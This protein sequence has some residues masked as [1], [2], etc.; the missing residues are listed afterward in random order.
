[1]IRRLSAWSPISCAATLRISAAKTSEAQKILVASGAQQYTEGSGGCGGGSGGTREIFDRRNGIRC[2]PAPRC[3]QPISA[4]RS[5]RKHRW[6][7]T[8]TKRTGSRFKVVAVRGR[9][10]RWHVWSMRMRAMVNFYATSNCPTI[11][12]EAHKTALKGAPTA[13]VDEA[14][15]RA[16]E[17]KASCAKRGKED[18]RVFRC[19]AQLSHGRAVSRTRVDVFSKANVHRVALPP[20]TQVLRQALLKKPKS[21]EAAAQARRS[22]FASRR[23]WRSGAPARAQR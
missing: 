20:R 14:L 4:D 18:D 5:A 12:P 7:R 9:L 13:K 21:G 16:T 2:A 23:R 22:V 17:L 19:G 1:M 8:P 3:K 6:S 15:K 10:A 11:F